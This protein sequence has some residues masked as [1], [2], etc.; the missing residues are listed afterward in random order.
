MTVKHNPYSIA[1]VWLHSIKQRHR[2]TYDSWD[3]GGVFQ[4]HTPGAV[5]EFK[6][7]PHCLYY[8]DVTDKDIGVEWMLVNTVQTNYE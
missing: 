4:V 6:S 8:L 5:V 7:S 2:V 1:N 3:H